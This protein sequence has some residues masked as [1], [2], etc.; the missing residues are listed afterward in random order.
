MNAELMDWI[1]AV[2][3]FIAA[4]ALFTFH[5]ITSPSRRNWFTLP[6]YIRKGIFI[7]GAMMLWRSVNFTVIDAEDAGHANPEAL[8]ALATT[9]YLFCAGVFYAVSRTYPAR[10]WDRLNY[11][12]HLASCGGQSKKAEQGAVLT[13]LAMSGMKVIPP[14]AGP[15]SVTQAIDNRAARGAPEEVAR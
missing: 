10:V 4:G 7:A 1:A 3:T 12:T 9:T 15:E 11:I 6:E 13:D 2:L 8:M 5:V 14:G